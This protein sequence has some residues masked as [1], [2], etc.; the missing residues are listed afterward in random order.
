MDA[1]RPSRRRASRSS[2]PTACPRRTSSCGRSAPR[3]TRRRSSPARACTWPP[4]PAPQAFDGV[5]QRVAEY[6]I[7]FVDDDRLSVRPRRVSRRARRGRI[8]ATRCS[9][10]AISVGVVAA[11]EVDDRHRR[12]PAVRARAAAPRPPAGPGSPR[13]GSSPSRAAARIRTSARS[14][15]ESPAGHSRSGSTERIAL[16][17]APTLTGC[18]VPGR[19]ATDATPCRGSTLTSVTHSSWSSTDRKQVMPSSF[20][21]AVS[22]GSASACRSCATP[23]ARAAMRAPSATRPPA[24]RATRPW[25]SSVRSSRYAIERCTPSRSA[26]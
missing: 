9:R 23:A 10:A 5:P 19:C 14:A 21:T 7:R 25:S 2:S 17:G 8:C 24:S 22:S 20:A 6:N 16:P 11:G 26:S 15:A 18:R 3:A 13:R 4:T 12:R 1:A